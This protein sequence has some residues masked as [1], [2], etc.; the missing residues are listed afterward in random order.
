MSTSTME[1][2]SIAKKVNCIDF[3]ELYE[4]ATDIH[5]KSQ[6]MV[7][8]LS[9]DKKFVPTLESEIEN[10]IIRCRSLHNFLRQGLN[11]CSCVLVLL[12]ERAECSTKNLKNLIDARSQKPIE[13]I[14]CKNQSK[15]SLIPLI[16]KASS[17]VQ[18][19]LA[20]ETTVEHSARKI[21][22][23]KINSIP[24][25]RYHHKT[26]ESSEYLYAKSLIRC[27]ASEQIENAPEKFLEEAISKIH[28]H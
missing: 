23:E 24:H 18:K 10:P 4:Q 8:L 2:P 15:D 20:M 21:I 7:V 27:K 17:R 28:L 12:E 26:L 16:K 22:K 14:T 19:L 6:V 25:N 9:W 3:T 1:F 11:Q 5:T 13:L